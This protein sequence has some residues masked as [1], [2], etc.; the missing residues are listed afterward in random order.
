MTH[1]IGHL[2]NVG[3]DTSF[4]DPSQPTTPVTPDIVDPNAPSVP[5]TREENELE[6]QRLSLEFARKQ[7][8][9]FTRQETFQQEQENLLK[10]FLEEQTR[11]G[12]AATARQTKLDAVQDELLQFQLDAI[13]Q[14]PGATSE[15][16][17]LIGAQTEEAIQ[18]GKSDIQEF[19]RSGLELLREELAPSLGL[20]PQDSPIIDRGGRVVAEGQRQAG[21]L[22]R[23]LR[24][25]Q[26]AAELNFP[27]AAG[28]FQATQTGAQ[29]ELSQ[30]A[31]Q[32]LANLRQQIAVNRFSFSG[33]VGAGG[34]ALAS[35][36]FGGNLPQLSPI[37]TSGGEGIGST[38]GGI[39][40]LLTGGAAIAKVF[41]FSSKKLKKDFKSI[42]KAEMLRRVNNLDV[43]RWKYKLADGEE[44]IGPY[45]EDFKKQFKT[46]DGVTINLLDAIGVLFASVQALT[47]EIE[48]LKSAAS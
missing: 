7:L 20:R 29:Q 41:G 27:L 18:F 2:P 14:G 10:P 42:N 11:L 9:A 48:D 47:T 6:I 16:K 43:E 28:Q 39:G 15:Q 4:P 3:Q 34:L 44:H 19:Q 33:G 25:A 22:V 1:R 21:Q 12:E 17:A 31:S 40:G 23:S 37:P 36:Q 38:F 32:F 13:R 30:S 24:G 35:T 8:E 5:P 26:S 45:A 46:G